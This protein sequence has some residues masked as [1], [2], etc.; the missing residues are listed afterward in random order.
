IHSGTLGPGAIFAGVVGG[1][2]VSL[3]VGLISVRSDDHYYA[4]VTL[5]ASEILT[6]LFRGLSITGGSN[7]LAGLPPFQIMGVALAQPRQYVWLCAAG[8]ATAL[9]VA[10]SYERSRFG[11][12]L[13]AAGDEGRRVECLGIKEA[14][15]RLLSFGVGGA[16]AGLGGG[17]FASVDRF[18]GPETF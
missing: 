17:L 10:R 7:G 14:P 3:A 16:L 5:A 11:L 6:N 8:A 1:C 2:T 9:V 12:A 13:R 15:L 18:V 4:F